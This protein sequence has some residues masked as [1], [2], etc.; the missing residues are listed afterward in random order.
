M[1][2]LTWGV[3]P[4]LFDVEI[5]LIGVARIGRTVVV[6]AG[7]WL[8][9]VV[10]TV[11]RDAHVELHA[12]EDDHFTAASPPD[13]TGGAAV[14]LHAADRHE[15]I[16]ARVFPVRGGVLDLEGEGGPERE[17]DRAVEAQIEAHRITH[18][19]D[20]VVAVRSRVRT[21][22]ATVPA[23]STTSPRK[24][25]DADEPRTVSRVEEARS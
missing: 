18:A 24:K 4:G 7:R 23:A 16:V 15:R 1:F 11:G 19:D 22:A 21:K 13:T 14:E 5:G 12:I 17:F 8:G 2:T 10:A 20:D 25:K 3:V 6:V 9:P